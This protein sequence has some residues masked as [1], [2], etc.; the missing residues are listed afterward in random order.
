M[1]LSLVS[2]QQGNVKDSDK[3]MKIVNLR[4]F[5]DLRNFNEIFRGKCDL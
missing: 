4:N 5:D 2:L 3:S 1:Q